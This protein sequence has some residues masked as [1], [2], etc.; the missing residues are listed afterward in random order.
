MKIFFV[1]PDG[2]GIRNYLYTDIVKHLTQSGH[3]VVLLHTL[4]DEAIEEV[5]KVHSYSFKR[6]KLP[7]YKESIREKFIREVVSYA[8]LRF[9]T[10]LCDNPTIMTNWMPSLR[11]MKLTFF[12]KLVELRGTLLT[13]YNAIRRAEI[14]YDKTLERSDAVDACKRLLEA[15]KPDVIFNTHQRAVSAVPVMKAAE[16]LGIER[17]TVIYSWDNLPKARLATRA[18]RYFVWSEYM[19]KEML[20]FYPEI[21]SETVVVTGTPQFDFYN[22]SSL[23]MPRESF[24]SRYG[25]DPHRK[26]ICFSGDDTRTSPYDPYYLEDLA[27]AVMTMDVSTRSQIL[28]RRCPADFSDRYDSVLEKYKEII[29]PADPLWVHDK[30]QNWSLFYP[31]YEDVSILVNIARHCDLVYNVGSTM[32]HD[33]AMFDKPGCYICYDQPFAE[34]WSVETIYRFE[35]FKSMDG[36]DAVVWIESK[37]EIAQKVAQALAVPGQVATDRKKWLKVITD[38][39]KNVGKSIAE[40]LTNNQKTTTK[41]QKPKTKNQK[42]TTNNQKPLHI[43]FLTHEYPMTGK[44]QGG[45]GS[46]VQTIGQALHNKGVRVSVVGVYNGIEREIYDNDEEVHVWRLPGAQ[47]KVANFIPN[48]K[49]L[50]KKLYQIHQETPIDII[51]GAELSFAFIPKNFPAKKVIRMH[52]GHHFFAVTLGK[53]PALWRSFQEKRSFAKAD[54]LIAVSDF[55]GNTTQ[56]LLH[57]SKPFE[58]IYNIVDTGKFYAAS[59]EKIIARKILF[60]G[61]LVEKKGVRQLV[62]AMPKILE[63]YPDATLDIVGRDWKDPQ[64]GTSYTVLLKQSITPQIAHAVRLVGALPH[65]E[66]PKR[67][68]EAEVC[69]YPSHM[70]AMPIAWLEAL[71]MG[72]AVVASKLGPGPEAVIDQK[73]GLLCNPLDPSDIAQKI[74]AMFAD[75]QKA[76]EMGKQARE[77]VLTRFNPKRIIGQNLDFYRSLI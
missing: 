20:R 42:P 29:T 47:W 13:D 37:E 44:T 71:G 23:I 75:R 76:Q 17:V 50:V 35:H 36:L 77:D 6:L 40:H 15:H 22:D 32:A 73:T 69:V 59:N 60:V 18:D 14:E 72:K 61:T 38:G 66:I 39:R 62:E 7:P 8:R 12:Y 49:R 3:E 30:G 25:L 70:E 33:F 48:S 64:T 2:V 26:I 5:E 52:G 1:V 31:S 54:G 4:S 34:N 46:V 51:E 41:N 74:I 16:A 68:E 53:K 58:T 11:S 56:S 27:Q 65:D 28:F 10:K 57:F 9:N 43:C 45:I 67:I 19:K 21:A 55:V 63:V 24:C